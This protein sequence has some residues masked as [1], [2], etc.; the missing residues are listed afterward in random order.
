M[1][2]NVLMVILALVVVVAL[3]GGIRYFTSPRDA[4]EEPR[5]TLSWGGTAPA[6]DL[7][8]IGMQKVADLV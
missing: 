1:K 5:V 7:T 8:S 4:A 3:Y 2:K 6:E